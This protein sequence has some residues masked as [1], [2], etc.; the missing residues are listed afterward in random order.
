MKKVVLLGDSIRLI[1]YGLRVPEL[2][3]GEVQ[4]WQPEENC[5]YSY[6]TLRGLM[7]WEENLKG[8]DVIHWN[9]GHWDYVEYFDDGVFT[10]LEIYVEV[11]C[12]IARLLL[13]R[14][15]KVIFATNTPVKEGA[16]YFKNSNVMK[17]NEALVPR[18]Q[19]MGVI[20]NDLYTIVAEDVES[21]ICDDCVHLSEAGIEV[22]AQQTA[23]L[24]RN[25]II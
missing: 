1:G 10:P 9:N 17:Y 12:R 7:D 5:R 20:I 16:L 14:C 23:R 18:L 19:E 24:I 4:V 8:A 6:R 3:E 25:M 21:Y 2:L 11:M 15:D 13:L 22:C